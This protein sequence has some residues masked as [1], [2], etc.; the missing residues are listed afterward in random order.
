ME[1]SDGKADG[2]Q[3][4]NNTKSLHHEP[5]ANDHDA[6]QH[7]GNKMV[8]ID[9]YN[10]DWYEQAS[11][12]EQMFTIQHN[13]KKEDQ[14]QLMVLSPKIK[15]KQVQFCKAKL[16]VDKTACYQPIVKPEDKEC[17]ATY[18]KVGKCEVWTLW[19]SGSM[20]TEI[21]PAFG[22]VANI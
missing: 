14:P 5:E 13:D 16:Q 21:T 9:T 1:Q 8:E 11:V 3:E 22:K 7:S 20:T 15:V 18:V 17:L 2:E 19:D 4:E 6:P 12:L 10:N